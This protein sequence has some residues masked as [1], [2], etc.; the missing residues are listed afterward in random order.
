MHLSYRVGDVPIVFSL[1]FPIFN[2]FIFSNVYSILE[3]FLIFLISYSINI[4]NKFVK[5][6]FDTIKKFG[7]KKIR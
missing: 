2:G 3:F 4:L 5:N 6:S 7:F 1:D